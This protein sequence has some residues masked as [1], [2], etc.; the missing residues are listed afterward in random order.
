[1]VALR[2]GIR[3][4]PGLEYLLES[5]LLPLARLYKASSV[6]EFIR[7]M[8]NGAIRDP[9]Q[10]LI[11]ALADKETSFFRDVRPFDGL[12]RSILPE[13]ISKRGSKRKL[14]FWSLGCS[15]GQEPYSLALLLR[16]YFP[17]LQ[18]WELEI[19]A[20][21]VSGEALHTARA[22]LY[23]QIEVNRGLPAALLVKHFQKDGLGWRLK[24]EIRR[25]VQ[26]SQLNLFESWP[27]PRKFDVI[28][29]RN[30]I[31]HFAPEPQSEILR[32]VRRRLEPDGLLFLGS[33]E[34]PPAIGE[35]FEEVKLDKG[36]CYRPQPGGEDEVE[37]S[38]EDR[39][40][41]LRELGNWAQL[42]QLAIAPAGIDREKV[43]ALLAADEEI[44]GRLLDSLQ[45][46][47]GEKKMSEKMAGEAMAQARR[48][49]L[50][51]TA[52]TTPIT[53]ALNESFQSM[54]SV[55]VE[56]GDLTVFDADAQELVSG[57]AK[58]S[59]IA[60]GRL[61][62]RFRPDLARDLT[63]EALGL[64]P[65]DVA[66]EVVNDF[67]GQVVS[68]VSNLANTSLSSAGL[69]CK[70]EAVEITRGKRAKTAMTAKAVLLPLVFQYQSRH[71]IWLDIFISA[72]E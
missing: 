21:D 15:T 63:V 29:L 10:N 58:L 31:G 70:L 19:L 40:R 28:L 2:A 16:E 23:N 69:K 42:A 34:A 46:E 39:E 37:E 20:S 38:A 5:R 12:R 41:K 56:P 26:F 6:N 44:K 68:L 8:Q 59:G 67:I 47:L 53:K 48:E 33:K 57:S 55:G 65:E 27:A 35:I 18:T 45:R 43:S 1:M 7:M 13:L 64:S 51:A 60:A 49:Q 9:E 61:S 24:E 4:E 36:L 32:K 62:V 71:P 30:V 22:G 17:D 3:F 66:P 72:L 25:R 50:F 54:L 11:E 52:V 14:S